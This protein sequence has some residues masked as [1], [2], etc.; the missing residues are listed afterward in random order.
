MKNHLRIQNHQVIRKK[1]QRRDLWHQFLKKHIPKEYL[2]SQKVPHAPNFI[3]QSEPPA[4]KEI[5]VNPKMQTDVSLLSVAT[6]DSVT[7]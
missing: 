1:K 4:P 5:M 6:G 7:P 2:Q 3:S